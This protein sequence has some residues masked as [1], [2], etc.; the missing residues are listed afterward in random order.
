MLQKFSDYGGHTNFQCQICQ[1]SFGIIPCRL[2]LECCF[3]KRCDYIT[4]TQ[5]TKK[6]VGLSK[7]KLHETKTEELIRLEKPL[8]CLICRNEKILITKNRASCYHVDNHLI[9]CVDLFFKKNFITKSKRK[10]WF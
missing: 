10:V 4:C 3:F 1:E 9:R 5:C 2:R 7:T 6:Y 8:K